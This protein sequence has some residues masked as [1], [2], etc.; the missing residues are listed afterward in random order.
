[1]LLLL[2][3]RGTCALVS[4]LSSFCTAATLMDSGKDSSASVCTA[5]T[6]DTTVSA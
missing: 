4:C 5:A 2:L 6:N 1:M 3:L